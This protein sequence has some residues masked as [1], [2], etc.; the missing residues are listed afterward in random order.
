M[1]F[2]NIF[3]VL[4]LGL[5]VAVAPVMAED[6]KEG[7]NYELVT[8]PQP[9]TTG[10]KV[11]VL[12][13]FWYGCPHC[14]R[15]EPFVERWLEKKPANAEFVRL[16]AIFR[17][18]WEPHARAFYTA[19]IMGVTEKVHRP[20]FNAIHQEKRTVDN[21]EKLRD[22]YGEQGVNKEEFTKTYN[23]FAVETRVGRAKMMVGRYG[24]DGVPSVIVNGKYRV[25]ARTAGGNAEMLKV[26]DYLVAKESVKSK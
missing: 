22:F 10:D 25:S 4:L 9:T 24:V 26:I 5:A 14:F 3:S 21:E 6:F 13:L 19:Q 17:A 23:S 11:E 16:P 7:V 8:P 20:L 12:E 18:E 15:F 2:A 1:R